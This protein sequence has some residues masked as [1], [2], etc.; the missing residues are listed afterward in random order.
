MDTLPRTTVI[1]L[2][3]AMTHATPFVLVGL[4]SAAVDVDGQGSIPVLVCFFSEIRMKNRRN[5]AIT[6][7]LQRVNYFN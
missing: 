6:N 4:V 2:Y 3:T 5:G 7:N 1:N